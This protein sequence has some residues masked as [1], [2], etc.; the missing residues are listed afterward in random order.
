MVA[1][2]GVCRCDRVGRRH[3][4]VFYLE[5]SGDELDGEFT[6]VGT[7]VRKWEDGLEV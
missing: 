2:A 5:D 7:R 6:F 3:G 4:I 1:I